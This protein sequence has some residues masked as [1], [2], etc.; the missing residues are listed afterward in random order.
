MGQLLH[1]NAV[2]THAIRKEIQ[3]APASVSNNA[4]A[5]RYGINYLTVKKWRRRSSVEDRCSGPQDPRSKSLSKLEEAVCV[6]FRTKTELP[7]DDCLF[8]L[9]ESIPHLKRLNL[10]RVFQNHGISTLPKDKKETPTTNKFR[11][12]PI[13]YFHIDSAPINTEEGRLYMFVAI[14]CTTKFAYV[15]LQDKSAKEVTVQFLESLIE[16]APY[17]IQTILTDQGCPFT[18]TRNSE[19]SKRINESSDQN[20]DNDDKCNSFGTFCSKN[21]FNHRIKPPYHPWANRDV[22]RMNRIF[23]EA[24]VRK[25]L[26]E[27][28]DKLKEY[29]QCFMDGYN[30]STKLKVHKGLTIFDYINK[31]W[32]E[33]PD[34][35]VKDPAIVYASRYN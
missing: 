12:Y 19:G 26:Y 28:H 15:E 8:S 35:F 6:Y 24:T 11:M 21:N 34:R 32:Q 7:L 31:C 9:Q 30:Q 27:S 4:V 22:E 20:N 18:N 14:D 23:N 29:I 33:E 3:E 2:A 1:N 10:H 5:T 17:I 13:R 25:Y 16:K